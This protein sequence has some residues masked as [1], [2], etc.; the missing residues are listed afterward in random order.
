[1]NGHYIYYQSFYH[2]RCLLRWLEG[3]KHFAKIWKP[4]DI[5]QINILLK[6]CNEFL[7]KEIHRKIRSLKH[8]HYYK[9]TEFRT[10]LLYV[11]IVV[12]KQ[13]LPVSQYQHFLTLFCAVTICSSDKYKR[14]LPKAKELFVEYI[15]KYIEIY[16]IANITSNVHNLCHVV[17]NVVKFG[18]L[19]TID[20]YKFENKL[21]HMKL[22]LK[23]CNKP[24][25]QIARRTCESFESDIKRSSCPVKSVSAKN[26]MNANTF[27][28]LEIITPSFTLTSNGSGNKYFL[29][30]SKEIVEFNYVTIENGKY[31]LFGCP[32]ESKSDFFDKPFCSRY[33]NIFKSDCIIT[34]YDLESIEAKLFSI[35]FGNC[36]VFIPLI[37]TL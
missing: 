31:K 27:T 29:T 13:H 8:I 20:A 34:E 19:N 5:N 22:Q 9:G 10:F 32:F 36:S 21:H 18:N 12:L 23:Q 4:A 37:H 11:G 3:E 24:L 14:F 28:Y 7:P 30:K 26:Q 6:R 1:M 35:P 16:H 15:E 25:Q 17:D 2:Y 33:I